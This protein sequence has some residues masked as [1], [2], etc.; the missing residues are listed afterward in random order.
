MDLF[1]YNAE[2]R[3]WIC[4]SCR[5]GVAPTSI[6]GHLRN[7]RHR[8]HPTARTE[9]QRA[10]VAEEVWKATPFNPPYG[11]VPTTG[12]GVSTHLQTIRVHRFKA[13]GRRGRCGRRPDI[14]RPRT[15]VKPVSCQRLFEVGKAS[16][17][18]IVTP[19]VRARRASQ[20]LRVTEA[21]FVQSQMDEALRRSDGIAEIED[22]IAPVDSDATEASPWLQLTRWP[23]YVRGH[24]F[25][26]IARL[27][28]LSDPMTEPILVLIE[29]SV[30]RLIQL[31]LESISSQRI[32]EFDQVKL[33]RSTYTRYQQVWVRLLSFAYR[34][35]RPGQ[36]IELR[37]QFTPAQLTAID[38]L[39]R[40]AR[41]LFR[42]E[43][44]RTSEEAPYQVEK[45]VKEATASPTSRAEEQLDRACLDLSIAL[46][47]H[48]IRADLFESSIVGFM[49]ALGIDA[50]T[51]TYRD[52]AH[53]TSHLSGLV[54]ISQMLVAQQ[55]VYLA[56]DGHVE[57]PGDALNEM[58]DRFLVYGVR[59]PFGWIARMRT[60]GKR[61][62]NT[63]TSLGYLIWS[64][65]R[66]SLHYREL[67][68]TMEGLQRFVRTQVEIAQYELERLFLL[69]E[70][71]QRADV[72]PNLPLHQLTDDPVNNQRGWNFL[73][74]KRNRAILSTTGERRLSRKV[75]GRLRGN[76]PGMG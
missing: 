5:T 31:A 23:E 65:D 70:D 43:N 53:Y 71:E 2:H 15:P 13:H 6:L 4:K 54:K 56:E 60:Y 35:S 25:S 11:T 39:E 8:T 30:R 36:S 76:V 75:A 55:A 10:A 50:R 12:P 49:A 3:L 20:A 7:K 41:R 24:A 63:S 62:Q 72:V 33:R 34:T 74:D 59:A 45:G 48:E 14:D 66:Q 16:H 47:D 29:Y 17:F 46:L 28:A 52:P 44:P 32:N 1:H 37:H 40:R 67:Q 51:Q 57:H 9:A 58:R 27:A 38:E 22:T 64:D 26:D 21:E 18:F 42:V 19:E 68:L 61:I 73:K 69:G